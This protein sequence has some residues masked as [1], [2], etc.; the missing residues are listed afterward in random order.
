MRNRTNRQRSGI[1]SKNRYLSV[2]VTLKTRD[3][4]TARYHCVRARGRR[5]ILG[6]L[7]AMLLLG[8]LGCGT[9]PDAQEIVDRAREVHGS[10][11]LDQAVVEFD[12]RGKHFRVR[13]DDGV[14]SYERI[15]TDSTGARVREVLN[16]NELFRTVNGERVA[17]SDEERR[18]IKTAVNSVVYFALLPYALNDPAVQKRYIGEEQ[19]QGEP[20]HRVEVTFRKEGGGRDYEDRFVYWFHQDRHTLDY[21]AYRYHTDGGGTRFRKAVNPREVNG[22]RFADYLNYTTNAID[23]SVTRYGQIMESDS[24]QQVSTVRLDNVQVHPLK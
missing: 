11:V 12:F 15:Y 10:N 24:L 19:V 5:L 7:A 18:S 1:I 3:F 17:L 16:N 20:Y 2:T 8:S 23:M 6:V 4:N 21:L 14:F 9:E 22:V 13:R